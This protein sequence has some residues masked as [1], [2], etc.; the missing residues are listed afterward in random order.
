[1]KFLFLADTHVGGADDSGYRQQPRY[2]SR[3]ARLIECLAAWI[4]A[5]GDIDFV[6]HGGD[7]VDE[8]T[9]VNIEAAAGFFARLPCPVYLALGN[10]DLTGPGASTA[11]MEAAPSFFPSG[12]VD[13]SLHRGG[14]DFELLTCHWG[15]VPF[16]WDPEEPQIPHFLRPQIERFTRRGGDAQPVKVVVTHAPP[17]GLPCCQTGLSVPLHEPQGGF[18]AALQRLI[19]DSPVKLVLGAHTH[20]NMCVERGGVSYVTTAAF[21]EAPFEFKLFEAEPGRLL[22]RTCSLA[23]AVGFPYEYDFDKTHVQGRLC[24]RV[25]ERTL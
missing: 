13:G 12:S 3:F 1:M 21:T 7:L 24:D 16:H 17:F 2:I 8:A 6:I 9:A 5:R 11:W 19:A 20:M 4:E 23:G 22:M 15:T 10:H 25:I 14:L 18:F